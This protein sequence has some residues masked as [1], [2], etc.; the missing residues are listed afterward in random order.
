M[1]S[2]R[3]VNSSGFVVAVFQRWDV[4]RLFPEKE[5]PAKNAEMAMSPAESL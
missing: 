1:R 5:P 2:M 4:K 3:S